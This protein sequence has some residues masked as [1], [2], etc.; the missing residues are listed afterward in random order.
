MVASVL[1]TR[2]A[3]IPITV[4]SAR[5]TRAATMVKYP[6]SFFSSN[7]FIMVRLSI[8]KLPISSQTDVAQA[9]AGGVGPRHFILEAGRLFDGQRENYASNPATVVVVGD[10]GVVVIQ[11]GKNRNVVR[12]GDN[13]FQDGLA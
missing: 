4:R 11:K 5:M 10:Y 3:E 9:H 13:F 6:S 7:G 8:G 2:E 12:I 1:A